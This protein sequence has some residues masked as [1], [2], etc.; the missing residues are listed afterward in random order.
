MSVLDGVLSEGLLELFIHL[1]W[2][3]ERGADFIFLFFGVFF[4]FLVCLFVCF[5]NKVSCSPGSPQMQYEDDLELMYFSLH[6]QSARIMV[7]S[8]F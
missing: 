8:L 2:E 3:T 7:C 6:L 4:F 5:L 1:V